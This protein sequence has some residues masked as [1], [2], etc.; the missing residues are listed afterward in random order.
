MTEQFELRTSCAPYP[1]KSSRAEVIA[2]N[3][4][5]LSNKDKSRILS[6]RP[7]QT[8][9]DADGDTWRAVK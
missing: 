6:L 3:Q 5:L 2:M 1:A 9:R 4:R 7:G 8:F